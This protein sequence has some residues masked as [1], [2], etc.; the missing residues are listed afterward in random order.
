M[1]GWSAP[2]RREK[3][4]VRLATMHRVKGLEFDHV[5]VVSA[6]KGFLPLEQAMAGTEDA[7]AERNADLIERSLLYVALTLAKKTATVTGWGNTESFNRRAAIVLDSIADLIR[8]TGERLLQP[9]RTGWV[10][11][12][13]APILRYQ[14]ALWALIRG[15]V[16]VDDNPIHLPHRAREVLQTCLMDLLQLFRRCRVSTGERPRNNALQILLEAVERDVSHLDLETLDACMV[17]LPKGDI[18]AQ[19]GLDCETLVIP[20]MAFNECFELFV[21]NSPDFQRNTLIGTVVQLCASIIGIERIDAETIDGE[22]YRF[23]TAGRTGNYDHFGT[24]S[25][26]GRSTAEVAFR[27]RKHVGR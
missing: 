15:R 6:N 19:R 27:P 7:V 8:A 4:G 16:V 10:K 12:D 22:S 2:D 26:W 9:L 5:F 1:F 17:C 3:P 23:P 11:P 14:N 21:N 13:D 20:D 24:H 18:A 25:P